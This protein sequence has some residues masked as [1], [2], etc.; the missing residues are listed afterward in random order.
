MLV[1]LELAAGVLGSAVMLMEES[2][3]GEDRELMKK[4]LE[5]TFSRE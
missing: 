2:Y 1:A 4:C 3:T 5:R